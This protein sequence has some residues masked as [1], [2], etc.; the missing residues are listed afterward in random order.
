MRFHN[1]VVNFYGPT[2][3]SS[4]FCYLGLYYFI[5]NV[6][7]IIRTQP[8]SDMPE[9]LFACIISLFTASKQLAL[10]KR[11]VSA[12][13]CRRQMVASFWR[14]RSMAV[15]VRSARSSK[16]QRLTHRFVDAF[17][18]AWLVGLLTSSATTR[19]Y[20]GRVPRLTSDNF[21]CR[22]ARDRAGRL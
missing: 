2:M 14:W 1:F 17:L 19:L 4:K 15:K 10:L 7:F 9:Q 20:R 18:V 12:G 13:V 22:Y 11:E 3:L 8:I 6:L 21:T 5:R 16:S